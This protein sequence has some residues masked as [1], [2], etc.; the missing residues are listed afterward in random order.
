MKVDMRF[1]GVLLII[2][3]DMLGFLFI[4]DDLSEGGQRKVSISILFIYVKFIIVLS[5][6]LGTS[7][8]HAAFL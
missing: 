6:F 2:K 1:C 5:F 7:R 3:E 8:N 4:F